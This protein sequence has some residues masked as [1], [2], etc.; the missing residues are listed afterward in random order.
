M[1]RSTVH[2]AAAFLWLAAAVVRCP[3]DTIVVPRDYETIQEGLDAASA[4]DSVL[5]SV[6]VYP[7]HLTMDS[8]SDGVMLISISG[9]DQTEVIG[10]ADVDAPLLS[11]SNLGPAAVIS[12]FTFRDNTNATTGG[13]ACHTASPLIENNSFL[14]NHGTV[15]GGA[16]I[17]FQGSF[18]RISGNTFIGNVAGEGGAICLVP[19]AGAE[20]VGNL[21]ER[22]V[23]VYFEGTGGG[24]ISIW[25]ASATV[26]GNTFIGNTTPFRGGAIY[27]HGASPEISSNV[28]TGN[29][30]A[31]GGAVLCTAGGEPVVVGNL[32]VGNSATGGSTFGGAVLCR[33]GA[34]P[35]LTDNVFY[36]NHAPRGSAIAVTQTLSGGLGLP[37]A[38]RCSFMDHPGAEV[39][40]GATTQAETLLFRDCWWRWND[41]DSIASMIWDCHDDSDVAACV[42]FSGWCIDPSCSGQITSV[43][44]GQEGV[45]SS[46]GRVKGLYR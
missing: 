39:W 7:E 44:E 13:V 35:T 37:V 1:T 30:A 15:A 26:T 22:N 38:E 42:D 21:F 11:C 2:I 17:C 29:L 25:G 43:D 20:I 34:A 27:V 8:S 24:A 31:G 46:W 10:S 41:P 32:F 14:D 45:P 28:F 19:N 23:A 9:P 16:I 5:V 36:G 6:G 33:G 18:P 3:A 4:G 40:I 12:G